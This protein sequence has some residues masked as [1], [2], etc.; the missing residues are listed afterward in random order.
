MSEVGMKV[1]LFLRK[2]IDDDVDIIFTEINDA[3]EYLWKKLVLNK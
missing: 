1:L 3:C 2:A